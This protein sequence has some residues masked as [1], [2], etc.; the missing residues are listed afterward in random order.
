MFL[1][2]RNLDRSVS[3]TYG[4]N[5]PAYPIHHQAPLP[6]YYQTGMSQKRSSACAGLPYDIQSQPSMPSSAP[7]VTS[8]YNGLESSTPFSAGYDVTGRCLQ[9]QGYMEPQYYGN[10]LSPVNSDGKQL[11]S[12]GAPV[13]HDSPEMIRREGNTDRSSPPVIN[14][15][16]R[17]SSPDAG[18]LAGKDD[19]SLDRRSNVAYDADAMG[20]NARSNNYSELTTEP[21]GKKRRLNSDDSSSELSSPEQTVPEKKHVPAASLVQD[22]RGLYYPPMP[23]S[24]HTGVATPRDVYQ[25]NYMTGSYGGFNP[26]SASK[27]QSLTATY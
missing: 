16:P 15:T 11:T 27:D 19:G 9:F 25:S 12:C 6:G 13:Y 3:P 14:I 8:M 7:G 24:Y 21:A 4:N 23:S 2:F 1:Y 5:T 17:L 26:V 18:S 20:W 10:N 22:S